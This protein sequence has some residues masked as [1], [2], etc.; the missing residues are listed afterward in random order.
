MG[1]SIHSSRAKSIPPPSPQ[2]R[3]A[4][5]TAV[6]TGSRLCAHFGLGFALLVTSAAVCSAAPAPL[7]NYQFKV[8]PQRHALVIGNVNYSHISQI[9]S[10]QAD[11]RAVVAKLGPLGF[12]DVQSYQDVRTAADFYADY[13]KFETGLHPGDLV[14]VYFSGHG[15]S[16]A[17]KNFLVPTE[18]PLQIKDTDVVARAI[19]VDTIEAKLADK[20][21][22]L[23]LLILDSCRTLPPDFRITTEQS[24]YAPE[25]FPAPS[26]GGRKIL[27][28]KARLPSPQATPVHAAS[29]TI[30]YTLKAIAPVPDPSPGASPNTLIAYATREGYAADG[31]SSSAT[32]SLYT[33]ALTQYIATQDEDFEF[34]HRQVSAMVKIEASKLGQFQDPEVADWSSTDLYLNPSQKILNADDE[35]WLADTANADH[36]A[37]ENFTLT[38]SLSPHWTAAMKWLAA[39][40][41]GTTNQETW[42]LALPYAV[43]RA[44]RPNDQSRVAIAPSNL[45]VAFDRTMDLSVAQ[46]LV[47]LNDTDLG[48][49]PSGGTPARPHVVH[50]CEPKTDAEGTRAKANAVF[51]ASN[52]QAV[53]I[54]PLVLREAPDCSA[55]TV[56]TIPALTPLEVTSVLGDGAQNSWVGVRVSNQLVAAYVPAQ[57]VQTPLTLELG[58]SLKEVFA[59]PRG[60]GFADLVD[61]SGVTLAIAAL[62]KTGKRITWIS[63]ASS[64]PIEGTAE[65]RANAKNRRSGRLVDAEYLL[66]HAGFDPKRLTAVANMNDFSGEAVRVRIF[67]Y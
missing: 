2:A 9:P 31:S 3:P 39:Y 59:P 49:I 30:S 62:R 46:K 52:D 54:K 38:H 60:I 51:V 63:L 55:P 26:N 42:S 7:A 22:G 13:R 1:K 12:R 5:T 33:H 41:T 53:A 45:P 65:E 16:F 4:A 32:M 67:G 64:L 50:G 11:Y 61:M 15:F 8:V 24:I 14:V 47:G 36:D 20:S 56:A 25:P 19:S 66:E 29:Q 34:D 17:G 43:E 28:G 23:I 57:A 48:L 18:F 35:A 44:W 27:T 40:P 6:N 10:A 37:I 21:P 58:H